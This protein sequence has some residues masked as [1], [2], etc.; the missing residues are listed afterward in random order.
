MNEETDQHERDNEKMIK[1]HVRS[2]DGI[3]FHSRE[4]RLVYPI[5]SRW[6]Y[7]LCVGT[8]PGLDN[9]GNIEG[10]FI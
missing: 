4:R 1:Q 6:N 10:I 2:H 9:S 5:D 7:P 8:R 3:S